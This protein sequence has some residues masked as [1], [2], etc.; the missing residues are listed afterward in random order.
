MRFLEYY[1]C[2]DIINIDY[3][4]CKYSYRLIMLITYIILVNERES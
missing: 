1:I 4:W 2:Y 3:K